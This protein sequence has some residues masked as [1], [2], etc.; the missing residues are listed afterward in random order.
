M[1]NP[2][3]QR[4]EY[5]QALILQKSQTG[6]SRPDWLLFKCPATITLGKRATENDITFPQEILKKKGVRILEVDRGGL[7]TFHGPGQIVGFPLGALQLHSGDSRAVRAF[8]DNTVGAVK[9]VLSELFPRDEWVCTDPEKTGAGLWRKNA[10]GT[11]EKIL[12]IGIKVSRQ[13]GGHVGVTH[14]FCLNVFRESIL[15][16]ESLGDFSGFDCIVA[17]G[18]TAIKAGYLFDKSFSEKNLEQLA[19]RLYRELRGENETSTLHIEKIAVCSPHSNSVTG[20][21]H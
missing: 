7:V 9:R 18:S 17:C 20:N 15:S 1:S 13:F 14:G 10:N 5:E 12:S 16:Q 21:G 3:L 11:F 19:Q 8:V 2:V 6:L 4:L